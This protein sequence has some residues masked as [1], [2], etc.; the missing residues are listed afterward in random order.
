MAEALQHP[1]SLT[2]AH[3]GPGRLARQGD[4][5]RRVT[6]ARARLELTRIATRHAR[7]YCGRR[8]GAARYAGR[9]A[10]EASPLLEQA[11]RV[12]ARRVNRG[13]PARAG[14]GRGV[15]GG[16]PA[17]RGGATVAWAPSTWRTMQGERG[18]PGAGRYASSARSPPRRPAGPRRGRAQYRQALALAEELEMRP[19]QAHCHLG[20][21]KLYR[22]IGRLDEARAELA[23]AVAMLREMGMAF[24]LPEAEAELTAKLR[25]KRQSRSADS[26]G[27]NR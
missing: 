21:G 12:G 15:S 23:T 7:P 2:L 16:R 27:S 13:P 4:V 10:A 24:W 9:R 19:L 8:L 17:R 1:Y 25:R 5:I 20:L 18:H 6:A 11:L 22:R 3:L 26:S 14:S